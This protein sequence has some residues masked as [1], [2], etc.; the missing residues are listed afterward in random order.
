[1]KD[2]LKW[3]WRHTNIE[4]KPTLVLNE[5]AHCRL[6]KWWESIQATLC[7]DAVWPTLCWQQE[8]LKSS[9]LKWKLEILE[10]IKAS[11]YQD[12]PPIWD[13]LYHKIMYCLLSKSF[14]VWTPKAII[15][16]LILPFLPFWF[17]GECPRDFLETL[18]IKK[19]GHTT[20]H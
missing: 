16:F 7:T 11:H 14:W 9:F 2:R 13:L 6:M 1:M 10:H 8:K 20:A 12:T 5:L 18:N 17:M 19:K 4:D 3:Y 15:H